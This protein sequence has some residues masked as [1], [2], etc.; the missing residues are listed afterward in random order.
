[1]KVRLVFSEA[2]SLDPEI[3]IIDKILAFGNIKFKKK[4]LKRTQEIADSG[5]TVIFVSHMVGQ[6]RKL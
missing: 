5:A 4:N 3:L 1:M 2:T 6:L